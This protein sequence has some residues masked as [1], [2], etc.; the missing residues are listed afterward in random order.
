MDS[1]FI[2]IINMS[3][4]AGHT[5]LFVL[6]ARFPLKKIPKTFSYYL[7]WIVLFRLICPF[8]FEGIFSLLPVGSSPIPNDLIYMERPQIQSGVNVVDEIV[9]SSLPASDPVASIN[10]IQIWMAIGEVIWIA[11]II[12]MI[13]Y[14]MFKLLKLRR[15]LRS[16]SLTSEGIY[17]LD[18]APTAFVYGILRPKIYI[19][20]GLS[21][22]EVEYIIQHERIHIKRFDHIIRFL[23][24]MTLCIHWF[25]PL[26]WVF[27]FLMNKDMELSCDEAV[28]RD[29]GDNIKRNYSNSILELSKDRDALGSF[30]LAFRGG[31]IKERIKNILN[32]KRPSFW[33]SILVSIFILIISIGLISNPPNKKGIDE[34]KSYLEKWDIKVLDE[35]QV[36]TIKVPRDWGVMLG[37][38]PEGLYWKIAN[39]FSKAV[40]LDME[41][42]K[43]ETLKGY[44]YELE[45]GL[46]GEGVQEEFTYSTTAAV[47]TTKNDDIVGSWLNFNIW[48]IGPSLDKRTWDDIVNMPFHEW[49]YGEGFF[50]GNNRNEDLEDLSPVEVIE[51]FFEAINDKDRKRAISCLG[52]YTLKSSLTTNLYEED[53]LYNSGFKEKNCI[54]YNILEGHL[55]SYILLDPE[56]LIELEDVEDRDSVIIQADIYINW[57]DDAFNVPDYETVRFFD[58][59][60]YQNG[61]KIEGINTGP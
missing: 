35:P 33:V 36:F 59:K 18:E 26:V 37:E 53:Y 50:R 13:I 5:I 49:A 48:D 52:P 8:T 7:W 16:A 23:A 30:P 34:A 54:V 31:D 12:T 47:L 58:L 29:M 60:K 28:I 19:P 11:G 40:G 4:I 10:P 17:E 61:W 21:K 38:Y 42:F 51:T 15:R 56:E 32:Y 57:K 41:P 45:D 24:Y 39:E 3:I 22:W 43:G 14:S 20:K 6:A 9:N 2:K 46:P 44:I 1:I 27:F 55:N 25:N